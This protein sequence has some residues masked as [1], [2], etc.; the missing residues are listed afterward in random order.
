ML[1]TCFLLSAGLHWSVATV[2][3]ELGGSFKLEQVADGFSLDIVIEDSKVGIEVC[4]PLS[5]ITCMYRTYKQG[6]RRESKPSHSNIVEHGRPGETLF[7]YHQSHQDLV[8]SFE[9]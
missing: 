1:A 5:K 7:C 2:L 4:L 8:Q 6:S 9:I 3:K